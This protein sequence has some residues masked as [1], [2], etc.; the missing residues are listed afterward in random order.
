MGKISYPP[1]NGMSQGNNLPPKSHKLAVF[2][3]K[4]GLQKQLWQPKLQKNLL[5]GFW[6]WLDEIPCQSI[7]RKTGHTLLIKDYAN[8]L[9]NNRQTD[10]FFDTKNGGMQIFSFS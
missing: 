1:A 7:R 3:E 8:S 2:E 6:F 10:K 9:T 5:N 4:I